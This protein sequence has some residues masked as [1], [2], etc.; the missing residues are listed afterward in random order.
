MAPLAEFSD[1]IATMTKI[2]VTAGNAVAGIEIPVEVAAEVRWP[3]CLGDVRKEKAK[4]QAMWH[5]IQAL[6]SSGLLQPAEAS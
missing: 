6:L 5:E 1:T 4:G 2:M 3:H